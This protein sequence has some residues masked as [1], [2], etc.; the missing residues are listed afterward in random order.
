VHTPRHGS[1]IP[2]CDC[3]CLSTQECVA[4]KRV[5]TCNSTVI[6]PNPYIRV[7]LYWWFRVSTVVGVPTCT[8][9]HRSE[10]Q[11]SNTVVDWVSC[12]GCS[13]F[14]E[15]LHRRPI[16][17]ETALVLEDACAPFVEL[18]HR[19]NTHV[20]NCIGFGRLT[21]T[22]YRTLARAIAN[23]SDSSGFRRAQALKY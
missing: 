9:S 17:V 10:M 22:V 5:N 15:L 3:S 20:A 7:C 4:P 8:Q 18:S 23:V 21:S 13:P 16:N 2:L 11:A 1:Y 12:D 19:R 6:D 14:V